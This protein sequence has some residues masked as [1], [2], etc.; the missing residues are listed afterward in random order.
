ML[1][2]ISDK[3]T[4]V[5]IKFADFIILNINALFGIHLVLINQD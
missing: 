4:E 2:R 3:V 1:T 5:E